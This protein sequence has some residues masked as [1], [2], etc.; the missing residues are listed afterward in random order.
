MIVRI[1]LLVVPLLAS[2]TD[3]LS[4]TD[5][6]AASGAPTLRAT[7]RDAN[8]T[9]K[10]SASVTSTGSTMT[11]RVAASGMAPG[12]KGLHIHETGKCE[13]PKFTSA[14]AHWNPGAKQHGRDNPAGAQMGD[15]PNIDI[16]AGG[17]GTAVDALQRL[18]LTATVR[19]GCSSWRRSPR[20]TTR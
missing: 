15:M 12:S 7:L 20:A 11:V 14:G 9:E 10:G 6:S 2:C 1:A 8:G 4:G 18:H 19:A 16:V 5:A 17:T 13:G 3:S